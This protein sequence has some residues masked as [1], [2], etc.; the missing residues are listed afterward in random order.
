MTDT[1]NGYANAVVAMATAEGA[2]DLVETEL[3]TVARAVDGNNELREVLT[4]PNKPLAVRLGFVESEV[5]V[6]AH[7]VTRAA[8]AMVIA[9]GRAGDLMQIATGVAEQAAA[10]RD[11]E[12]AEVFV[13]KPISDAQ[14]EELRRALE[15]RTGRSLDLQ[16]VV[17]PSV[18][19]GVRAR[20]GD[21][22]IDGSVSKRLDDV[23]SR[24]AG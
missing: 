8:L 20:I 2:I 15:Q 22:V 14:R 18:V 17:D 7:P 11:R 13:A 19:G 1:A 4:D 3:L 6:A 10:S 23:R 16:V 5:L 21:T 9:G 12:L 24:M